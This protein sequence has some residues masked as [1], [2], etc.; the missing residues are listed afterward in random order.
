MVNEL[1]NAKRRGSDLDLETCTSKSLLI[2]PPQ[3]NRTRQASPHPA[4]PRGGGTAVVPW[5][6]GRQARRTSVPEE[7]PDMGGPHAARTAG[8]NLAALA[9]PP[10]SVPPHLHSLVRMFFL[11]VNTLHACINLSGHSKNK[12]VTLL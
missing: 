10:P 3:A 8:N 1:A 7:A 9:R 11:A 2:T 6:V 12:T 4:R 5:T